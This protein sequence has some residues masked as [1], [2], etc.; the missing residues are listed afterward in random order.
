MKI[1]THAI[2][3]NAGRNENH[4]SCLITGFALRLKIKLI[5]NKATRNRWLNENL[6]ID[7]ITNE[8][9]THHRQ[10]IIPHTKYHI[11]TFSVSFIE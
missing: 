4:R 8:I 5:N 10:F 3:K 11:L 1:E 6:Y 7:V 2:E 9:L